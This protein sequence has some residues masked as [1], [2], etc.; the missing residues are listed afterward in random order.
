MLLHRMSKLVAVMITFGGILSILQPIS[1]TQSQVAAQTPPRNNQRQNPQAQTNSL[2]KELNL[3]PQQ[4]TKAKNIRGQSQEQIMQKLQ[5]LQQTQGEIVNMMA[6]KASKEQILYKYRQIN[7]L[8]QQLAE[9]KINNILAFREIL[10][11]AQRRKFVELMY[12]R[13]R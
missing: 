8:Q 5:I 1:G 13:H 4:I 11:P 9:A 3:S 7:L 2:F 6:G 10:T 12:R